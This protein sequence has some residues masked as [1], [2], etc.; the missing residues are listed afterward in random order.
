[1]S[2]DP[3]VS[4]DWLEAQLPAGGLVIIDVRETQAYEVGHIP[5]AISVPFSPVSDWA[6][7]TDELLMELPEEADLFKVIGGCG[8]NADSRVV[9]VTTLDKPPAPPYSLSDA[10]RVATTLIY[11][12]VKNVAILNGGH[13]K[14]A[15]E[16]KETT[17]EVP[18]TSPVTYDSTVR[19]QMFVSTQYVKDHIG[20]SLIIDGRDAD[21]YFGA[22]ID[23]FAGTAGHIP[24]A[25]S[26]PAVWMWEAD[27]TYKPVELLRQM[28]A[29]VIEQ[30]KYEEIIAYCGVGGYASSWWFVLTQMLG[31]ANVKIYDGAAEA[32]AKDNAMVLYS[33]TS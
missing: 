1:R 27:G 26:L 9:I 2:I 29:G 10:T 13:P 22:K 30:G 19:S 3:I 18:D 21:E 11:A 20:S 31:Y 6:T 16:D 8:L 32:W 14:W 15:Q 23:P 24:T 12:G 5:Y 7:S 17:T 28:A 25:R 4:T 33:W